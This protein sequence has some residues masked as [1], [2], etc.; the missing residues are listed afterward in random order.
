M[1]FSDVIGQTYPK[2]LLRQMATGSRLPHALLF[3]GPAGSGKKALALA[4]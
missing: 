2:Q 4:L 3:L 1:R